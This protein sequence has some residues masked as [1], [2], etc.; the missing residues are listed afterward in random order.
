MSRAAR[1]SYTWRQPQYIQYHNQ[2]SWNKHEGHYTN[3]VKTLPPHLHHYEDWYEKKIKRESQREKRIARAQK[4]KFEWALNKQGKWRPAVARQSGDPSHRWATTQ[5][6][7]STWLPL[8]QK[9]QAA[10]ERLAKFYA[11]P[12]GQAYKRAEQHARNQNIW[13]HRRSEAAT[14]RQNN[15][16]RKQAAL[17]KLAKPVYEFVRVKPIGPINKPKPAYAFVTKPQPIFGPANFSKPW[18]WYKNP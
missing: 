10:K 1:P 9:K 2:L 16:N 4:K 14:R 13:G 3:S 15:W 5:L 7:Q 8:E 18:P 17:R 12:R 6:P 11:T